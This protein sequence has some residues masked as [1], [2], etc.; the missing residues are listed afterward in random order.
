M[1]DGLP[2]SLAASI[3]VYGLRHFKLKVNGDL[4]RDTERLWQIARVL[5]AECGEDFAFTLDGN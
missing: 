5:Q 2:Q 3:R 4:A 1:N